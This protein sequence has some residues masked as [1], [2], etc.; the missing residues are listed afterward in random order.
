M[1]SISGLF[2]EVSA[3]SVIGFTGRPEAGSAPVPTLLSVLSGTLVMFFATGVGNWPAWTVGPGFDRFLK[4]MNATTMTI[5]RP[6]EPPTMS[7][8]RLCSDFLAAACWTAMRSRAVRAL[9]RVALLIWG[10]LPL[11]VSAQRESLPG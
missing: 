3:V 2:A 8:L 4:A 11:L 9:F 6:T 1:Y 7:S 5:T 10:A